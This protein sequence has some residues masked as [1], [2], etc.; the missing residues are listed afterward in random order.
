MTIDGWIPVINLNFKEMTAVRIRIFIGYH[1]NLLDFVWKLYP[2]DAFFSFLLLNW[3]LRDI[4]YK[5]R[6]RIIPK[7]IQIICCL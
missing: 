5:P 3:F 1:L 7:K 6:E 2:R 4:D